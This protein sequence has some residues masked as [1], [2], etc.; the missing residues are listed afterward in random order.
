MVCEAC[1]ALSVFRTLMHFER[2]IL[3]RVVSVTAGVDH[4]SERHSNRW[5][6]FL[7]ENVLSVRLSVQAAELSFHNEDILLQREFERRDLLGYFE[8]ATCQPRALM[9]R[10]NVMFQW[11][12]LGFVKLALRCLCF[13]HSRISRGCFF[14]GL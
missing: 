6:C 10:R 13:G 8:G 12:A 4:G 7:P 5:G 9:A 11:Q 14:F 1:F 3:L 2:L